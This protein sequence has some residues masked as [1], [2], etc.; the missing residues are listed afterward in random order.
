MADIQKDS[1]EKIGKLQLMEHNIHNLEQQRQQMQAQL[2]E[3]E[4][5]IAALG[6]A[7][8]AYKIVGSVMVS[9]PPA[10]ALKELQ[11]KKEVLDVRI[12]SVEKQEEKLR[13]SAKALQDEVMNSLKK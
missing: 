7:K 2:F 13:D 6:E 8:T 11:Q 5:A 4:S 1:Q 12:Q 9:T 3:L 10:T